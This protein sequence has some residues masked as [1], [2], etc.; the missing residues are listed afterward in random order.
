MEQYDILNYKNFPVGLTGL[1]KIGQFVFQAP[2]R[3][4]FVF[5]GERTE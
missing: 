5:Q 1:L 2:H 3:Q 4:D